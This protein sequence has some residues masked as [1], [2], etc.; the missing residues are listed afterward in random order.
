MDIDMDRGQAPGMELHAHSG[1][2]H[3]L[4]LSFSHAIIPGH[5][6]GQGVGMMNVDGN[7]SVAQGREEEDSGDE[8]WGRGVRYTHVLHRHTDHIQS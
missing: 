4:S 5:G 3:A 6:G 2:K 7:M 1:M 8:E